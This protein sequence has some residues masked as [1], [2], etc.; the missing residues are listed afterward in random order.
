MLKRLL[1]LGLF[2]CSAFCF[3]QIANNYPSDNGIEK[4]ANVLFSEMF[5][6]TT[7]KG[8]KANWT[9][10]SK[11]FGLIDFSTSVPNGS[12][13]TQSC[14]ITTIN[15]NVLNNIAPEE[16]PY[17]FKRLSNT[18]QDSVFVRFYIKYNNTTSFHHSGVWMGGNYPATNWPS[19]KS[20][21]KP[22]GDDA[23]HVGAEV[24]G[25]A[26]NAQN[27]ANFGFY[28]YWMGMHASTQTNPSTG[29]F[30]YWGNELKN[31]D[32][33]AVLDMSAWNCVE[34]RIKLNNPVADST[35]EL[36]MW[37]NGNKVYAIGKNFP[38]GT[39][40]SNGTTLTE[41]TGNP[42]EG[43]RF[44]STSNLGFNYVWLT[45]YATNNANGHTSDVLYDH[46]VVAKKYIGPISSLVLNTN[47]IQ[48]AKPITIYP[49]PVG[50]ELF[51]SEAISDFTIYN[52][53]GQVVEQ[54]QA[55]CK[56]ISVADFRDGIYFIQAANQNF[57][58][59]VQ[60]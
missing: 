28:N 14:K 59:I 16:N 25:T 38:S 34:V 45:N 42:F 57:K 20:G 3:S 35:G 58:F 41:G 15:D 5:E 49:N 60:H 19:S 11:V 39:Y 44:R 17:L 40:G 27:N 37:I 18:I 50:N 56:S 1:F 32:P 21:Y 22:N 10:T 51:F 4:D 30:Y 52:T 47:T 31:S 36:T 23:F 33:N 29:G 54:H 13:G 24:R 53:F 6:E 8:M 2:F 46:L 48:L 7:L 12:A 9:D 26:F 43:L 55:S